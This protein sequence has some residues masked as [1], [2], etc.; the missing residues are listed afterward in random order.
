MGKTQDQIAGKLKQNN[1]GGNQKWGRLTDDEA[2]K[3]KQKR[4]DLV[5]K[6]KKK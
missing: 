6:L 1:G 3:I 5:D 2:E 4:A